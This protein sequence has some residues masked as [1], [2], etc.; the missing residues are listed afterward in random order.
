MTTTEQAEGRSD[1]SR[2]R[3]PSSRRRQG[4]VFPSIRRSEEG[5]MIM[6]RSPTLPTGPSTRP[7]AGHSAGY[8]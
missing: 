2:P 6:G 5:M 4:F 1:D 8:N 7:A 3:R